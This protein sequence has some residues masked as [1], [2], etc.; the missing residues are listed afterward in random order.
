MFYIASRQAPVPLNGHN[1]FDTGVDTLTLAEQS[2]YHRLQQNRSRPQL[3][4]AGAVTTNRNLLKHPNHIAIRWREPM[5]NMEQ[6]S[7]ISIIIFCK[8]RFYKW[9]LIPSIVFL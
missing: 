5:L 7:V 2:F 6:A 9:L 3:Q 8:T 1:M 4:R